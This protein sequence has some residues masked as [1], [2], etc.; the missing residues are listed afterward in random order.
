MKLGE[1]IFLAWNVLLSGEEID[2]LDNDE[3]DEDDNPFL[4]ETCAE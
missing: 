3:D 1:N 2:L 4:G